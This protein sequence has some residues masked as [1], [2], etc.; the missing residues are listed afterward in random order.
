[1]GYHLLWV[2]DNVLRT[3]GLG[4]DINDGTCLSVA[5]GTGAHRRLCSTAS[6]PCAQNT[7]ITSEYMGPV[8][9]VVAVVLHC[10]NNVGLGT[11]L[12]VKCRGRA[13]FSTYQ[14]PRRQA[15]AVGDGMP[16]ILISTIMALCGLPMMPGETRPSRV[17]RYLYKVRSTVV[18]ASEPN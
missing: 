3:P 12:D 7:R 14:W 17:R 1:M 16:C 6:A 4:R 8:T 18:L 5:D 11:P 10:W 13:A 9:I 2:R 15:E